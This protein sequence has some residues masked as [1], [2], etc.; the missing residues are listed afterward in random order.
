MGGMVK[1]DHKLHLA[2]W[3]V[4]KEQQLM[5]ILNVGTLIGKDQWNLQML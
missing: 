2:S 4:D 1:V 5:A 3:N